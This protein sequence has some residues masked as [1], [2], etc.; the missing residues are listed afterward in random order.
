M[1]LGWPRAIGGVVTVL[2]LATAFSVAAQQPTGAR[3]G[4][5]GTNTAGAKPS[6]GDAGMPPAVGGDAGAPASTTPAD[7]S[8]PVTAASATATSNAPVY[9]PPP[10]APPLPPPTPQ[11]IAAYEAMRT[12]SE[13][14]ERG[15]RDYR[16]TITTI[17]TLHYEEKKK[18][19]LGGLDREV[20]LEKEELRKARETAIKRLEEFVAKYSGPNAQPEATPDAMY[21]LAALYEERGRADDDADLSVT[22][23]PAIA[24]YKRVV[25]E[26]PNYNELAG[27][28]YFLGHALNDARRVDEAQ[29]VWR[30]LVCRNHY[31]YPVASDPKNA[32]ADL[33]TPM[34]QDH[35]VAYWKTWR[36]KYPRPESLKKGPREDTTFDDPYPVD[37][38]MVA[39]PNM[40][41][42]QEPKYVAE[43]WWRMGDWEFDQLD[44]AGG[45]VEYEPFAVWD[46]NRA[47]SA[48]T[49]SMKY[50]KPPV[51]GV[52]LY[53]YAW[54]LFKQQRYEAAVH[55]FV[56]LLNYTD[57]QEKLTGDPGVDFRQEAYTYIAGSLDNFDFVGPPAEEPF[58]ARPDILE[59]AKS[60][61]EAE[62]K[63][64][65]AIERLQTPSLIPQDKPWT[66]EIYKAL[67]LE[68]RAIN[69]YKN[70]LS[71]YQMTL[72]KWP[73]DPAAPESQN[74][75]AEVYD[76]LV[77]QTKVGDERRDY[78]RKV[79]EART[80]LAKYI[81]DT[82]WVD[83]N[84][85]NPSALQRAEELVRTGL[86]GAAVTHTRNAQAAVEQAS[87]TSDP[88]E[89][90]RLT[91]F[92][93]QE[94]HLAA[95]G[96]LGYLKQDENAPDAYKSRYF[97]ADSLHNQSPPR[98]RAAR[99]R[100]APVRR[101]DF[102][103]DRDGHS[104]CRRRARLG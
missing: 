64:R 96:W 67:A 11:Q 40:L 89:Q 15:A 23:R 73:M 104:C 88:K 32:D 86:K 80:A 69:Q 36:D 50:K 52:A 59:T 21:R 51:Y 84:K 22:L 78:E 37:C 17:I 41:Q 72:D 44:L 101:A 90:L 93:L 66:I 13:A 3:A 1:W 8:A 95:I 100:S 74:A 48:Y 5:T 85:D 25:N 63:L 81:G 61:A 57:E 77:R 27:I 94:Y 54:T 19:I 70:A 28:Y 45:V 42:G 47:A 103:R 20:G 24:L 12:Q 39:Q 102:R 6:S 16:D 56:H 55:E 34:P 76:L 92:A 43:I 98:G 65:V 53:K 79:L 71:V 2:S 68:F 38:T 9:T 75:I 91:N 33:I 49:Q 62:L 31:K 30:S 87:Q 60:P 97:Y 29:Q 35:D 7:G 99:L 10:H 58:I 4:T 26:F 18:A 82:P 83:A 14:Y 46:Y